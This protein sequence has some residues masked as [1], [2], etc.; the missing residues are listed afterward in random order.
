MSQALADP[1][2][3]LAR[4]LRSAIRERDERMARVLAAYDAATGVE[5]RWEAAAS[6]MFSIERIDG[7]YQAAKR[8]VVDRFRRRNRELGLD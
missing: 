6:L 4:G 3:E 8:G 5:E 7:E 2:L 1:S